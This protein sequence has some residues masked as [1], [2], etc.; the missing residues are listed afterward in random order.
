MSLEDGECMAV[1]SHERQALKHHHNAS[2]WIA[3]S[4]EPREPWTAVSFIVTP[5]GSMSY[6]RK[7]SIIETPQALSEFV[8]LPIQ[9]KEIT[10]RPGSE[11]SWPPYSSLYTMGPLRR[12]W[13][14]SVTLSK[15]SYVGISSLLSLL[16]C[17]HRKETEAQRE[18]P[19]LSPSVTRHKHRIQGASDP[20]SRSP[21]SSKERG[22][23]TETAWGP[24][25]QVASC[26]GLF[27]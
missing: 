2:L 4:S 23:R 21:G 25:G 11:T 10:M 8:S 18:V 27:Y 12:K 13:Q 6:S 1:P 20:Q 19:W 26:G 14:A 15:P 7:Y 5:Q 22:L 24:P 16:H 3:S 9:A 17:L